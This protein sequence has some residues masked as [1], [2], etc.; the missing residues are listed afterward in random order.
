MLPIQPADID[1]Y[2]LTVFWLGNF[3]VKVETQTGATSVNTTHMVVFQENCTNSLK[4]TPEINVPRSRKRK[5]QPFKMHPSV[6]AQINSKVHPPSL[7]EA[8]KDVGEKEHHLILLK[9]FL[10]SWF[11]K[12]NSFDQ[13]HPLSSGEF[14]YLNAYLYSAFSGVFSSSFLT[15]AM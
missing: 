9:H 7:D 14:C 1:S 4:Q 8:K 6:S 10:W 15:I 5:I 13:I 12:C 3:D 11:R 2:V